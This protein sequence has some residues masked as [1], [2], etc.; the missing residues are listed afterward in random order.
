MAN[1]TRPGQGSRRQDTGHTTGTGSTPVAARGPMEAAD[2][3][4]AAA[5]PGREDPRDDDR[6]TARDEGTTS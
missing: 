1:R 5:D 4:D 6:H 3:A 2:R